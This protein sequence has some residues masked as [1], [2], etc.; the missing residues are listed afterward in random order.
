[1]NTSAS[2]A[3]TPQPLQAETAP[4]EG[5]FINRNFFL[6]WLGQ[7][8]SVFGDFVFNTTLVVWIAATIGRGQAGRRWLSVASSSPPPRPRSS[9]RRSL[10]RW[11]IA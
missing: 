9:S 2:P 7:T 5:V 10:G 8:G 3:L 6:L 11:W 4:R 1:M